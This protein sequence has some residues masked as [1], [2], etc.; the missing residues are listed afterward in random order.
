MPSNTLLASYT[1]SV[2]LKLR[3]EEWVELTD[4]LDKEDI[5]NGMSIEFGKTQDMCG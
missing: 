4:R 3:G 2:M 5:E 1:C